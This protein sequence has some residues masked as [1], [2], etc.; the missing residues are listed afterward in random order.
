M[1]GGAAFISFWLAILCFFIG[2]FGAGAFLI[3]FSVLMGWLQIRSDDAFFGYNKPGTKSSRTETSKERKTELEIEREKRLDAEAEL[4]ALKGELAGSESTIPD[5]AE[6][7]YSRWEEDKPKTN[8]PDKPENTREFNYDRW[9][10]KL[11]EN[12]RYN[13]DSNYRLGVR[14]TL[15]IVITISVATTLL[16]YFIN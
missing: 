3:L 14:V 11:I 12:N 10:R 16:M 9:V 15:G 7:I 13:S 2:L 4:A 5:E 8:T 6:S 1:F